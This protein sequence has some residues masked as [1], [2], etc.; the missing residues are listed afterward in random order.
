MIKQGKLLL[1]R[2]CAEKRI[3]TLRFSL[4]T[5]GM[6]MEGS[7]PESYEMYGFRGKMSYK[8]DSD[9]TQKVAKDLGFKNG[10]ELFKWVKEQSTLWI[11]LEYGVIDPESY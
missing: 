11:P 8:E 5:S 9:I 4:D 2:D 7:Y 3:K 1:I 10:K 6:W